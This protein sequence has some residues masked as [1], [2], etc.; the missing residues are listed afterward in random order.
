MEGNDEWL[1]E[2]F[3]AH[4]THLHAVAFRMLGSHGEANDPCRKPGCVS[5]APSRAVSRT[6]VGGSRRSCG[7]CAWTCC[8]RRSPGAKGRW[9]L[10]S[11]ARLCAL[12]EPKLRH[13]KRIVTKGERYVSQTH[14]VFSDSP[15]RGLRGCGK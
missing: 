8:G 6:W 12:G 1:A 13:R 2:Q 7:G 9:M 3:E 4:R 15:R 5:A 11:R 10:V 14:R